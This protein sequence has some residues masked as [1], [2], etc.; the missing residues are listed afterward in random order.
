MAQR[1]MLKAL[2]DLLGSGKLGYML[3]SP[4]FQLTKT[5]LQAGRVAMVDSTLRI[6]QKSG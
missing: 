6:L 2:S 3:G 5:K 4:N 1:F